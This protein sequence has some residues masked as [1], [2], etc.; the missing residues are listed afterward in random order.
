MIYGLIT[1][2]FQTSLWMQVFSGFPPP[3]FWMPVL[4]YWSLYRTPKEGVIMTYLTTFIAASM[5]ALPLGVFLLIN[6]TLY[7]GAFAFKLKTGKRQ[8]LFEFPFAFFANC[9]RFVGNFLKFLR[10]SKN[11]LTPR[12]IF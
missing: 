5:S 9:E 12:Y 8:L 7:A 1:V 4:A 3:H 10:N 6:L 11:F 2:S